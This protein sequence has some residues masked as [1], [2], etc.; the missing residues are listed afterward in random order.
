MKRISVLC[1]FLWGM[2]AISGLTASFS[3]GQDQNPPPASIATAAQL[4]QML[5]PIAL[6][7]DS[8]LSQVLMASTYPLEIV[9][10]DRWLKANPTL[11]GDSLDSALQSKTWDASVKS[12]AYVPQV[13][14]MLDEKLDWTTKLG[15][16]FLA[17]EKD[18]MDSIQRLR[19]K[20]QAAGT[21]KTTQEQKVVVEKEIIQIQPA[22]PQVV[23]VPV[24]NPTV[25]YGAWAYPAYPPY[26][27]YPPGYVA[28]SNFV[29]FT[30]GFVA[31]AAL[32]GGFNWGSHNVYINNNNYFFNRQ[33]NIYNRQNNLY[34]RPGQNTWQH[35]PN[36]RQ[37]VPYGNQN[38]NQ[39]YQ[40]G[41]SYP[42]GGRGQGGQ[43]PGQMNK[44]D[45][46]G[47]DKGGSQGRPN[48]DQLQKQLG[49][50][51]PGRGGLD[52]G[53]TQGP[54]GSR[55]QDGL[56]GRGSGSGAFGRPNDG[57]WD[58]AASS[59]G[60]ASRSSPTYQKDMGGSR[61]FSGGDAFKGSGGGRGGS[62]GGGGGDAF[63]GSG[64]GGRGG[65]F[66]GGRGTGGGGRRR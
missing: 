12:L 23:Y 38:L 60:Q 11:K 19:A 25:V 47:Y 54:G 43:T 62:F 33:T 55:G 30:A 27:V 17:Q 15:D 51:Q 20:A 2:M 64:G 28:A 6:Y 3:Y 8:L 65:S 21:L 1:L 56:G 7:P 24:Y 57:G 14:S 49:Q 31:G 18:V 52:S 29:S 26:P 63:K 61:G 9:E 48:M 59:R 37:G 34:N 41:R 5:A 58:K 36:H 44:G 10:A 50:T 66:G 46:R 13:L 35:D 16:T 22:N 45:F 40:Q 4:D 32:Y 39:K 53:R 42:Q